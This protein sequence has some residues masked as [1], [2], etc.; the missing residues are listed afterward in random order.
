MNEAT[1]ALDV[2]ET[3][4]LNTDVSDEALETAAAGPEHARAFTISMC[5]GQLACPF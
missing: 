2:S 3:E 1:A 4:V 5:T